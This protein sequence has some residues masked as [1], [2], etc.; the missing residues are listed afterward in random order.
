MTCDAPSR[1]PE[2][3]ILKLKA[4]EVGGLVQL[5]GPPPSNAQRFAIGERVK[6]RFGAFDGPEAL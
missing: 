3:E 4:S 6:I 5:A 1:C 2:S